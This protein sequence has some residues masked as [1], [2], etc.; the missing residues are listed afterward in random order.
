MNRLMI[1]LLASVVVLSSSACVAS[2]KF[3]RNEVKTSSDGLTTKIDTNTGEIREVSDRVT[4]VNSKVGELDTRT[5]EQGQ[6][7]TGL[8]GNVQTLD[9][10][11]VALD[12]KDAVLDDKAT[13]AQSRADKVAGDVVVLDQKFQNRNQYVVT[14]KKSILFK[15]NS[16]R[17]DPAYQAEL[18]QI[19]AALTQNPDAVVVLEGRTDSIGNDEYNVALGERR[20]EAVKRYLIVDKGVPVYKLHQISFGAAQPVADNKSREGRE[21]NRAVNIL[22]LVPGNQSTTASR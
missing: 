19:A 14:D 7:I 6:R 2:R 21:K 8:N 5:N 1:V 13:K 11:T 12:Q 15:F 10:K 9:Q 16:A 17:V 3:V 18:D 20:S 4:A 22:L